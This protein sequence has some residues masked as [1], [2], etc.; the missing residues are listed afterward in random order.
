MSGNLDGSH[1]PLSMAR[2]DGPLGRPMPFLLG[3]LIETG[4]ALA[5]PG[6]GRAF[7]KGQT[8]RV[9]DYGANPNDRADQNEGDNP[10]IH[11]PCHSAQPPK[12]HN[13]I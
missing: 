10:S 4:E 13:A 9:H 1:L 7:L 12:Q 3:K 8:I 2:H 11:W 6:Q 5:V